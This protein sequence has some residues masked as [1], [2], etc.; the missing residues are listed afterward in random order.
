ML[1]LLFLLA[2]GDSKTSSLGGNYS[3]WYEITDTP[4]VGQRCFFYSFAG[5]YG[6]VVCQPD[7][8]VMKPNAEL[9]TGH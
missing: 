8:V 6:G 2:C 1:F 5:G 3:D 7:D 9:S 4:F